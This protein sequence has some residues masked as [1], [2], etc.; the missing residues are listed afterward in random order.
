MAFKMKGYS[1]YDKVDSAY[2]K[3]SPM[4]NYKNPEKY[5][6]FNMGNE[7]KGFNKM[8]SAYD[9]HGAYKQTDGG[10]KNIQIETKPNPDSNLM[11]ND[12]NLQKLATKYKIDNV[13]IIKNMIANLDDEAGGDDDYS[14][15]DVE[16]AIKNMIENRGDEN[17]DE[18]D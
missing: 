9:K 1:A 7:P 15:L 12:A 11:I 18:G 3:N 6:V 5:K 4:K 8:D 13:G 2:D 14:L 16:D 17:V 10:K